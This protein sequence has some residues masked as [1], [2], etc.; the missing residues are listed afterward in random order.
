MISN[1]LTV[2]VEDYFH[3][4]AF[5]N[6]ISPENW[7]Q[8]ESR[9]EKNTHAILELFGRNNVTATF[10]ILGWVAE[11]IPSLVKEIAQQGHEIA[12]HGFS[13][14]LIYKQEKSVF[15]EETK[16]AKYLL[17]DL[18]GKSVMGYRAASYSITKKSLW[19]L[20][21]L[22]DLGFVYDSSIVPVHHDLYGIPGT[23]RFPYVLKAP[24]DKHIIEF[25]PTTLSLAGVNIPIAGGGYFRLYPFWF[26]NAALKWINY[27]DKKPFNFYFH[28]WEID[29][30]QPRMDGKWFSKFRHY[31]N[32]SK[33]YLRLEKLLKS[34]K[35]TTVSDVLNNE[36]LLANNQINATHS[37]I[38]V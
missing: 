17:E 26:S 13:H 22:T 14:Q 4:A 21:V 6:E 19:A 37:L 3:V 31:N 35:F 16:K 36:D 23:P 30:D 32:I 1:A 2:D 15:A 33:C 27:Y 20:D 7:G 9:V 28:P 11:K 34:H 8:F 5:S 29:E 18:S 12:C 38:E 24:N 10:F 25:P